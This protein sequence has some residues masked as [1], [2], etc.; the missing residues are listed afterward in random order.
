MAQ[1]AFAAGARMAAGALRSLAA[2]GVSSLFSSTRDPGSRVD[3]LEIQTSSEGAPVPRVYGRMRL[4]GQV[5]W[6]SR[7]KGNPH[8]AENRRRQGRRAQRGRIQLFGELRVALSE[9]PISGIGRVWANGSPLD[10]SRLVMRVYRGGEDQLPDP[11]IAMI[12]GAGAAP[13][14]RG[15]AYV[16]FEDMP[17]G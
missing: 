17:L 14:Y 10:T 11:L 5:I 12:E 8:Q 3:G 7:F 2:F 1:M 15:L 6:A 9:G 16:V 13:A 4:A